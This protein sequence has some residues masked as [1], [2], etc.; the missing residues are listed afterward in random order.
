MIV[1]VRNKVDLD[2][3]SNNKLNILYKRD[4]IEEGE[5]FAIKN[6]MLIFVMSAK[7]HKNINEV[8]RLQLMKLITKSMKFLL[9]YQM[10]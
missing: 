5:E 7:L 6:K 1:L 3:K 8:F 10:M 9:I 4:N 2:F